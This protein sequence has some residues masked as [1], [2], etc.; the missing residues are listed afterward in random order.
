MS[1]KNASVLAQFDRLIQELLSG[2]IQR[3]AF[4]TWEIEILLDI[5]SCELSHPGSVLRQ[6]QEAVQRQMETGASLP[7]KLSEY[8]ASSRA[9]LDSRKPVGGER[10]PSVMRKGNRR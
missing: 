8:M 4:Q 3:G 7:M 2:S 5:E 10:S 1:P 6:Y 9:E